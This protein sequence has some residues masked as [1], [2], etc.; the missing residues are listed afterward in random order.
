MVTHSGASVSGPS[1]VA[2]NDIAVRALLMAASVMVRNLSPRVNEEPNS[3]TLG[4]AAEPSRDD[5]AARSHKS[6]SSPNPISFK[7]A[8]GS[9]MMKSIMV[10]TAS[11]RSSGLAAVECAYAP[12]RHETCQ[13]LRS[14]YTC[15]FTASGHMSG[16][17]GG[18]ARRPIQK[19]LRHDMPR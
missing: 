9:M 8:S 18:I 11:T 6:S 13:L 14:K 12:K 7:G 10:H 16:A 17:S 19:P 2:A 15:R 4:S 3:L 5:E 1:S